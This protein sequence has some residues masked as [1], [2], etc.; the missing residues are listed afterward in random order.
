MEENLSISSSS[1]PSSSELDQAIAAYLQALESGQNPD[2]QEFIKKYPQYTRELK[3]FFI[4]HDRFERM[5]N[6]VRQIIADDRTI[7]S[8]A[9]A[10][11]ARTAF[12]NL[13]IRYVGDYEILEEIARGG[14]G[15]VFKAQ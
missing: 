10:F 15:I 14:M 11:D 1:V 3:A 5:A 2:R 12:Q 9:N 13:K 7:D 4:D 6:P 8:D